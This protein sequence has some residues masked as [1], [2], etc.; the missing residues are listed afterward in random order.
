VDPAEAQREYGLALVDEPEAGAY[1]AIVIAVAH[2]QIR[3]LGDAGVHRL[4]RREHVVYD[5][6]HVL[7]KDQ[8]DGRL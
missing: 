4:G 1:D 3:D 8:V 2:D 5:I 7:R 6:K